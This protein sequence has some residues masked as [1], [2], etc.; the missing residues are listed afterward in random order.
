MNP[1]ETI[2]S[3]DGYDLDSENTMTI[4]EEV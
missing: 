4:N 3:T 2:V 1:T